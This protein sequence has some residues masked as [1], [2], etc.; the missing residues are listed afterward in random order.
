MVEPDG[1]VRTVDYTADDKNGFNAVVKHTGHHY[2]PSGI[3]PTSHSEIHL[4]THGGDELKSGSY[5]EFNKED[6]SSGHESYL[7]LNDF[8]EKVQGSSMNY[9]YLGGTKDPLYYYHYPETPLQHPATSYSSQKSGKS[10]VLN[11]SG[12]AYHSV[13]RNRPVNLPLSTSFS[14]EK[15]YSS[16]DDFNKILADVSKY[17]SL[18]N[19]AVQKVEYGFLDDS[20]NKKISYPLEYLQPSYFPKPKQVLVTMF[21][22]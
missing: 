9:M 2:H 19:P 15:L 10:L 17:I 16:G 8:D 20:L 6:H 7:K 21:M 3:K 13:E 22:K 18:R 11:P 14:M 4:E 12:V 1:S 5:Q